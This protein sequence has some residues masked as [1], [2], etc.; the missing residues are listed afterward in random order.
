MSLRFAWLAGA[1]LIAAVT[2]G[3]AQA[4]SPLDLVAPV[5][6]YK[7]YVSQ[8]VDKLVK[9]IQK[10][11]RV[12]RPADIT[13]LLQRLKALDAIRPSVPLPKGPIEEWL[14]L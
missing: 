7:L 9:H 8:G 11:P 13:D 12:I 10:L 4:A 14:G 2:A 6:A 1:S 5:A 3:S